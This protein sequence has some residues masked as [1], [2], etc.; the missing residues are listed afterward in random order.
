MGSSSR[1]IGSACAVAVLQAM[2]TAFTP[3]ARRK[4]VISWLYRRTVSGLFGPY[5]TRAVSPK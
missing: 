2:T 1:S 5:G 3:S 4:L